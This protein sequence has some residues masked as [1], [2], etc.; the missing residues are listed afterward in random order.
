MLV[1]HK[2]GSG[3][4]NKDHDLNPSQVGIDHGVRFFVIWDRSQCGYILLSLSTS[5]VATPCAKYFYV[6]S[7]RFRHLDHQTA[8]AAA[9]A[10]AAAAAAAEAAAAAAAAAAVYSTG[11]I[12]QAKNELSLE[13]QSDRPKAWAEWPPQGKG[14]HFNFQVHLSNTHVRKWPPQGKAVTSIFDGI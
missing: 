5:F 4:E 1:E 14:G 8:T 11:F 9:T 2:E 12:T 13:L 10:A 6:V 7:A 3:I